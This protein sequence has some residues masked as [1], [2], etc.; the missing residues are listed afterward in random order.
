MTEPEHDT[1]HE[2]EL[3]EPDVADVPEPDQPLDD[4]EAEEEA[5]AA[6]S[7]ADEPAE[8]SEAQGPSQQDME[9]RIK[10]TEKA[11]DTYTRAVGRIWE[12]D[13]QA[14]VP[15]TIDPFSPLGFIDPRNAGRADDATKG[16]AMEFLGFPREQEYEP[17]PYAH[18]CPT[19]KGKTRTATGSQSNEYRTRLCPDCKGIGYKDQ[20]E[21]QANGSVPPPSAPGD[22]A[23]AVTDITIGERDNW[24]EPRILP[25]GSRNENYGLMPQYK[26]PHPVYGITA[27]IGS[28][29]GVS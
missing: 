25:D 1:E 16:A 28:E 12:E 10:K 24:G 3:T 8:A 22:A 23:Q 21:T 20:R 7:G 9:A 14:F 26:R 15:F 27:L 5:E 29:Q 4:P 13:A 11:F 6:E 18:V 17:D 19:C 2:P